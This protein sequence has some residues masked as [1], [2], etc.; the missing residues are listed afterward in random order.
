MSSSSVINLIYDPSPPWDSFV[1][2]PNY[3]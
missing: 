3:F 2:A 1:G